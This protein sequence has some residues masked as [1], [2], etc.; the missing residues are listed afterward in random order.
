[1]PQDLK[2]AHYQKPN[3][4]EHA[5]RERG[6]GGP[7]HSTPPSCPH[8]L[9]CSPAVAAGDPSDTWSMSAKGRGAA[10]H[11]ATGPPCPLPAADVPPAPAADPPPPTAVAAAL[12]PAPSPEVSPANAA[13]AGPEASP[14]SR[15]WLLTSWAELL[16][17]AA[18]ELATASFV[19]VAARS[20]RVA[21]RPSVGPLAVNLPCACAAHMAPGCRLPWRPHQCTPSVDLDASA[22]VCQWRTDDPC[23]S[24]IRS[25]PG[26]HPRTTNTQ[27]IDAISFT[28]PPAPPPSHPPTHLACAWCSAA[29]S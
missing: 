24:Q 27:M 2:R 28:Q 8:A 20:L 18:A 25:H 10:T 16:A 22:P 13:V 5:G 7:L 4:S 6:G 21:A 19:E 26:V 14:A 3:D 9:T 17:G 23:C 12:G 11:A 1:M 29:S 15:V